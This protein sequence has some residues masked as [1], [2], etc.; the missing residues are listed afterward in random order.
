[1]GWEFQ[2]CCPVS[3]VY[4]DVGLLP[5][6][7]SLWVTVALSPAL[8]N[9]RLGSIGEQQAPCEYFDDWKSE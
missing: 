9:H 5:C 8:E 4:G 2:D 6:G 3:P 1:M 7:M